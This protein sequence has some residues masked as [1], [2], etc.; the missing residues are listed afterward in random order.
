MYGSDESKSIGARIGKA[1][2]S[3]GMTQQVLSE[4]I[5][6]LKGEKLS[7]SLVTKWENGRRRIDS[8]DIVM[9]CKI[10]DCSAGY[11]LGLEEFP[12]KDIERSAIAKYTGL[13][14][15][16]VIR[17]HDINES[18]KESERFLTPIIEEEENEH[19]KFT[20]LSFIVD[21]ELNKE[22]FYSY[23]VRIGELEGVFAFLNTLISYSNKLEKISNNVN[24][25]LRNKVNGFGL[26]ER[27][28]YEIR[29]YSLGLQQECSFELNEIAEQ[30]F[31]QDAGKLFPHRT[32]I[33]DI[34]T[35]TKDK[36][37]SEH[38]EIKTIYSF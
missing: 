11:L 23:M 33:L 7:R 19:G 4:K 8:E 13:T 26:D 21:D 31:K 34:A 18:I 20:H 24:S 32:R 14:E 28:D 5:E 9:L 12:D 17:L 10:L 30:I 36:Y 6:K 16:S 35:T 37:K 29:I 2:E 25:E 22:S 27:D 1:R 38:P 15:E 3:K